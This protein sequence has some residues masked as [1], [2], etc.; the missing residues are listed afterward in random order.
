RSRHLPETAACSCGSGHVESLPQFDRDPCFSNAVAPLSKF[1][2]RANVVV[3]VRREPVIETGLNARAG[4]PV[5]LILEIPSETAA[6]VGID[7][8][9]MVPIEVIG[10]VDRGHRC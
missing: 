2:A 1:D 5:P 7:M 8:G 3:A 10:P 6:D 4:V 9:R